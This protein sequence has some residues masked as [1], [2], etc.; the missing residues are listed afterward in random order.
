MLFRESMRMVIS[1]RGLN[2][3]LMMLRI[4]KLLEQLWEVPRALCSQAYLSQTYRTDMLQLH[5]ELWLR[6]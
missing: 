1:V 2:F 6:F 5:V 4:V 3:R